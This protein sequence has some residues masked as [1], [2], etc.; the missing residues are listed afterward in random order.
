M[1]IVDLFNPINSCYEDKINEARRSR[2]VGSKAIGSYLG[3][4]Y[5]ANQLIRNGLGPTANN[6]NLPVAGAVNAIPTG[7]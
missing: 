2:R 3:S 5:L 1:K 4:K 7:R 6:L